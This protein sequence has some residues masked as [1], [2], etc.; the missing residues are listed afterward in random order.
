MPRDAS[1]GWPKADVGPRIRFPTSHGEEPMAKSE[2][3]VAFFKDMANNPEKFKAFTADP[4][5]AM[6][7]AGLDH[8]HVSEEHAAAITGGSGHASTAAAASAGAACA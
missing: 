5:G 6:K 3:H 2:A 4:H 8:T 1:E 7:A